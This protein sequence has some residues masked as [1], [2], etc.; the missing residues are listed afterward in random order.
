MLLRLVSKDMPQL[1]DEL[2]H[3]L[4]FKEGCIRAARADNMTDGFAKKTVFANWEAVNIAALQAGN[5]EETTVGGNGAAAHPTTGNGLGLCQRKLAGFL[6][7]GQN[8]YCVSAVKHI[9]YPLSRGVNNKALLL[10]RHKAVSRH[11]NEFAV[12]IFSSFSSF[13]GRYFRS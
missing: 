1:F 11:I 7:N 12:E 6:V 4:C 8:A 9:I 13:L 5:N 10:K 3:F 2:R